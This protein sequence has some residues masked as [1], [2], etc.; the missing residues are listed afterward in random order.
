MSVSASEAGDWPKKMICLGICQVWCF[1]GE[2]K[3]PSS[4]SQENDLFLP[5]QTLKLLGRKPSVTPNFRREYMLR[6]VSLFLKKEIYQTFLTLACR[7]LARDS[8]SFR[9]AVH[10]FIGIIQFIRA[11][12]FPGGMAESSM[13][14]AENTTTQFVQCVVRIGSKFLQVRPEAGKRQRGRVSFCLDNL[15]PGDDE[16][17]L[18]WAYHEAEEH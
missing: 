3:V 5:E 4:I 8:Q 18:L 1:P 6:T 13:A 15:L 10:C 17:A 12:S 16:K 14:M 2:K 7:I 9:L 11:E